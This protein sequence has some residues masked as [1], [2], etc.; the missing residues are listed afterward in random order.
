MGKNNKEIKEKIRKI[1][2]PIFEKASKGNENSRPVNKSTVPNDVYF[3]I[4]NGIRLGS[5]PSKIAK[6]LNVTKQA[7]TRYIKELK[8][9]GVIEKRG[10]GT[11]QINENK[12]KGVLEGKQVNKSTAVATKDWKKVFTKDQRIRGHGF[13]ITLRIPKIKRWEQRRKYL[14]KKKIKYIPIG[15]NWNGE[16]IYI[17]GHKIWLTPIS[18]VFYAPEWKSWFAETS[19]D[20]QSHAIYDF[21]EIIKKVENLLDTSFRIN[22]QYKFKVS[23]QHYGIVK[24]SLAMQYDKTGKKLYCYAERGLIYV[25]DNSHNLHE[26]EGLNPKT[27]VP[28]TQ[29]ADNFFESL[30]RNPITTDQILATFKEIADIQKTEANKWN[31]YATNIESHTNAI[32]KLEQGINKL[33]DIKAKKTPETKPITAKITHYKHKLLNS[34][35]FCGREFPNFKITKNINEVNCK[36]CIKKSE[37][38]K[39]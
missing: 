23:R 6:S 21:L 31:H 7:L 3:T 32:I 14:E 36:S 4:I 19:N 13:Q 2:T 20:S 33:V 17:K 27:A 1:T 22:K 8:I 38:S 34:I 25:I 12:L 10:Y 29:N 11:W 24:N 5:Y 37:T 39:G 26:F 18:I 28:D 15:S 35:T 30:A 9:I 16:R